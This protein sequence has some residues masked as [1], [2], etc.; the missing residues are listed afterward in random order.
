VIPDRVRRTADSLIT[1]AYRVSETADGLITSAE[2]VGGIADRVITSPDGVGVISGP[3]IT[4]P[5]RPAPFLTGERVGYTAPLY[6]GRKSAAVETGWSTRA[7]WPA[8]FAEGV[9]RLRDT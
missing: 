5:D 2:P 8:D 6:A 1:Y 3:V 7:M 4:S 9:A